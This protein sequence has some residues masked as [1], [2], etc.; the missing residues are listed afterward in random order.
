M[1]CICRNCGGDMEPAG[2]G[3]GRCLYCKSLNSMPTVVSGKLER[4]ERVCEEKC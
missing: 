3:L 4:A 2:K 1:S